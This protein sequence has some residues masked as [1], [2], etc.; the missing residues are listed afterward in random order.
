MCAQTRVMNLAADTCS[1]SQVSMCQS[2]TVMSVIICEHWMSDLMSGD[3][4]IV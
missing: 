1:E 2:G 3:F 4:V